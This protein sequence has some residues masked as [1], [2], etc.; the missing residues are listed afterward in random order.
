MNRCR[1]GQ[2]NPPGR[3]GGG[4]VLPSLS[5]GLSLEATATV[6]SGHVPTQVLRGQQ[7]PLRHLPGKAT[8]HRPS[9]D[10]WASVAVRGPQVQGAQTCPHAAGSHRHLQSTRAHT[11]TQALPP[12]HTRRHAST[13]T[14]DRHTVEGQLGAGVGTTARRPP[15]PPRTAAAAVT[16][17]LRTQGSVLC[18]GALRRW[19]FS[20][21]PEV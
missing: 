12:L 9:G 11:Q 2:R 19:N 20:Q 4:A 10:A 14:E 5:W 21:D 8:Q 1:G 3:P 6:C 18:Q 7:L 16:P 13:H 17:L 15:V